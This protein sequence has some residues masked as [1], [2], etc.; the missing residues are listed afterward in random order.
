MYPFVMDK[1]QQVQA[2]REKYACLHHILHERA[3]RIWAATEAKQLGWAG[4][5]L[6]AEAIHMSPSYIRK[7]L[8]ELQVAPLEPLAPER[9]RQSGGGRKKGASFSRT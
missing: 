5:S 2:I 3:R 9:A 1:S 6:V 4:I 7:G 8:R